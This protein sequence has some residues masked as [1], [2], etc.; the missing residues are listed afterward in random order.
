MQSYDSLSLNEDLLTQHNFQCFLNLEYISL[1]P[2]L[3]YR[4]SMTYDR[5]I[6]GMAPI[7]FS[8][9]S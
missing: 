6:F 7:R 5:L 3:L 1:D 8:P 9:S 4:S 2:R